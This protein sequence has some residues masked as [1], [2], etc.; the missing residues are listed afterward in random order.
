LILF[1][2]IVN[3]LKVF[4]LLKIL[5]QEVEGL[6]LFENDYVE[7]RIEI[8]KEYFLTTNER[9]NKTMDSQLSASFACV[10]G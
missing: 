3:F 7:Q 4:L 2:T 9:T 10:I 5:R 8:R 1:D 6:L